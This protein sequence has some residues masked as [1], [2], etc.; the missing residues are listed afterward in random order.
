MTEIPYG[1]VQS[2]TLMKEDRKVQNG[3]VR[4]QGSLR[5]RATER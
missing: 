5:R 1:Q 4:E 3:T 2:T